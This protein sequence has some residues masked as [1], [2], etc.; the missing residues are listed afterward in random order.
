[1]KEQARDQY[2]EI[3]ERLDDAHTLLARSNLS[4]D[5]YQEISGSLL[6]LKAA[7]SSAFAAIEREI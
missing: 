5:A 4:K 7:V 1:M 3:Y 6:E 2:L